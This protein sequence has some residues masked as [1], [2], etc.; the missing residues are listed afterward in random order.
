MLPANGPTTR[1]VAPSTGSPDLGGLEAGRLHRQRIGP[2]IS[3][4][5]TGRAL[6]GNAAGERTDHANRRSL[7]GVTRGGRGESNGHRDRKGARRTQTPLV[8]YPFG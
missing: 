4:H 2:G 5:V 8:G 3:H 6:T 7:D 1:T